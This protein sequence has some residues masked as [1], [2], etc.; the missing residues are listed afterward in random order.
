MLLAFLSIMLA[1]SIAR[2]LFG[3]LLF[4]SVSG[5]LERIPIVASLYKLLRQIAEA[6]LGGTDHGFRSVVLVEWP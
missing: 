6:F 4:A 5:L 2:N 1:G 3:R